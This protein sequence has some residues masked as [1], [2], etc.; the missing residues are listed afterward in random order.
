MPEK[1]TYAWCFDHGTL[2]R[3]PAGDTPWCTA[4]WVALTATTE[5]D[6]LDAKH[7]AWGE[8]RFLHELPVTQQL[9][10]IEIGEARQ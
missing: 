5:Q 4:A 7:A 10:V 1:L 8:A 3:F 2:H 6:A 9:E